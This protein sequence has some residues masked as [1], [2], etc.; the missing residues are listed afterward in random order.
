MNL[1]QL[2]R[3]YETKV[4]VVMGASGKSL[5]YRQ[6]EEQS[7]AL[8]HLFRLR[9]LAA[10]DHIA[11]LM[12]N[13][14]DVFPVVWAAQRSGLLYTP[15]N[16]H[17]TA[18][19]AAYIVENCGARLL[20]HSESMRELAVYAE[21]T[22]PLVKSR[23]EV[24]SDSDDSLAMA[25][26][27]LPVTPISDE[28]EGNYM[29]YSSGTTGRPK[30]ILPELTGQPFG[31]GLGIDSLMAAAF[32][33]GPE[34]V[35]LSPGPLYHAAPLGWCLGTV[36]NGGTAV[37]MEKFD[38]ELTLALIERFQVTHGQFVPTMFVRMLKLDDATRHRYD[39]TSMEL[40]VHAAAPCSIEVKE[41]M[42]EW[43]GPILTEFYSGSEG[44]GFFMIESRNWLNHKGSVGKAVRGVVHICDDDGVELPAGEIGMVWFSDIDRFEYYGDPA[45][46]AESFNDK[47]WNTLGD[48]G[49]VDEEGYLFLSAR[50]SD[51]ILSGGVNIYPQEI[52]DA[53]AMHPAVADVA[54]I[55]LPDDEMGQKVHAVIAPASGVTADDALAAEIIKYCRAHMAGYKIPRS[56]TFGEVPRLPS[57]KILRRELIA[58]FENQRAH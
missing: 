15:V 29:F 4:A 23:L 52:E 47:G 48:L 6:L 2:A 25:I 17:L 33:F 10:G 31:S 1:T 14:I 39:V 42:I 7:N 21:S 44:T 51:L 57:G 28:T 13:E 3:Q 38:A 58:E 43:F 30:G 11:I 41:R 55:G 46:T 56:V 20:V 40:V 12:E 8:A 18:D 5:T 26:V 54:A 49:H 27:G 24:G 16:W 36:R 9:G 32:G 50:R 53:L 22:A 37:V 35:Y 19:E 45:K 34:A